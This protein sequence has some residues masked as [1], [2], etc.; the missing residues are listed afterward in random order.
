AAEALAPA[1]ALLA[2]GDKESQIRYYEAQAFIH[3]HGGEVQGFR[4]HAER[5]LQIAQEI[6][7]GLYLR[8]MENAVALA[9]ASN[10]DEMEFAL[11]VCDRFEETASTMSANIVAPY[12]ATMAW[13]LYLSGQLAR[14]ARVLENAFT[15]AEDAP[16]I[17]FLVARTGIPLALHLE[18]PLLLRRCARPRLLE[19]AFASKT[20]NVFGPVAAAVAAQLRSDR[21]GDEAAALLEQTVKR[22]SSCANNLPL[23]I[24]VARANAGAAMPRALELVDMLRPQSRSA[25]AAWH[26]CTAYASRGQTR[27]QNA[28]E[29]AR[30]FGRVGWIVYQAEALELAGERARA[31]E[32]YRSCG[33]AAGV[34]R[35]ESRESAQNESGL[36]KRE[37]EVAELVAAGRSNKAIA[38]ELVLSERTVENHIAAIF[39]KLNLRSRTEVATFF[40]RSRT[41]QA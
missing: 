18:D 20:P 27:A 15:I 9:L 34:R 40:T 22:L 30:I 5:A 25:Q 17:A 37:W 32:I 31:L 3:V 36:S 21:R 23:M 19:G 4:E 12:C 8:R 13:P 28:L 26:L 14:S 6:G 10:L 39:T 7:G 1:T 11:E 41:Q 33:S 29:A 2:H 16:V 38:A 35:L 24:E